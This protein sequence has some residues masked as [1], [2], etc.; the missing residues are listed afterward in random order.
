MKSIYSTFFLIVFCCLTSISWSQSV[1]GFILD[2]SNNPIPFAKVFVKNF[3]NTGGITNMEGKYSF[4]LAEG[5]YEIVYSC[6]GFDSQTVNV[7]V[8]GLGITKQNIYLIEAINEL[9]TVEVSKKRKN[10]GYEIVKKVIA[11]KKK[12]AKQFN[13]YTCELYIKGTET[14][15]KKLKRSE[16]K[17][18]DEDR[19]KAKD[20]FDEQKQEIKRKIENAGGPKLNMIELGVTVNFEFPNKVKEFK[21]ASTKIGKPEQIYLKRSPV[22]EDCYFNFYE[23]LLIKNNLHETPIVSPLH[24]SAILS[25]K[26]KLKEI[27]TEG[28]DTIYKIKISPRSFGTSTL[29]GFLYVKK[30]DYVLTKVDLT[31]HK[32]NLKIYDD[33]RIIQH[34]TQQDS[35]WLV[36]KQNF[37][38]KTKYG[39]ETIK[40]ETSVTYSNYEINPTFP[41]KYFNNE[42][43]ITTEKAYKRDSTYWENIRP[44][45][46]SIQE[47]RKKFV[48]D[49]LVAVYTKKEYLDSVDAV[50]NSITALKVLFFGVEGRN[51]HKKTQWR[52]SSL[53]DFIEPIGIAGPRFGPGF[54]A[55]KKFKNEQWID[56]NGDLTIGYL[57]KDLR[58]YGRFF[59]RYNP[60]KFATYSLYYSHNVST[61]INNAPFFD[62]L[63]PSNYYL[64]DIIGGY[65]NFELVNGLFLSTGL[66]W[67][68]RSTIGNLKFYNLFSEELDTKPPIHFD[69]Y[70]AFRSNI[71]LSYTPFQKY[72]T[73][74]KRKVIL[75]SK[76]PTFQIYY[77]KGIPSF[78]GSTVDF[79]YLSISAT[80]TFNIGTLGKSLYKISGGSFITQDSVYY[81]DRKFFRQS[82]EGFLA[83]VFS[84]P[85]NSFQNL[86]AAYETRDWYGQ[87]HY[88]HHFNGA[89]I[90]KIPYMK[91]TGIKAVGGIGILYLPEYDHMIY[92]EAFFGVERIFKIFRKRLRLGGF[93]V[94]S[95][96]NIQGPN[97]KFKIAVDIMDENNLKFNF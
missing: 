45:P 46:L 5:N 84:D 58:G 20:V 49:S 74:P 44:E 79:D 51:R 64:R 81:I 42:I 75:G 23:N 8:K 60:K 83:W 68:K 13:A 63:D 35:L 1:S 7:T 82:D 57:N 48:Q 77:E 9:E 96:S 50:F 6:L 38:Y 69:S 16:L 18:E 43:G 87:F 91:K 59:H 32:G 67:E 53:T 52:I 17:T 2:E 61:I 3:S 25:Y 92:Q 37:I 34:Y 73:E 12:L 39:R 80:Q 4:F 66:N 55:F 26:Y 94:L 14:F 21:T 30:H 72:L 29:E 85:L 19:E 76:W 11:N 89:L 56:F 86:K 27:I 47:Q 95:N 31:M 22:T 97:V 71:S 78:L 90:N 33:F 54:G 62:Y 88:I 15:D 65:H 36:S 24:P 41:P 28:Q 93:A 70:F 40:G 10:V